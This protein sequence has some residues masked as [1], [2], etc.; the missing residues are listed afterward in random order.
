MAAP[1]YH[2]GDLVYLTIPIPLPDGTELEHPVLIISNE[3]PNSIENSYIAVMMSATAHT[4]R[5]SFP[6]GNEMFESPL[7]K[8]GCNFRM[9]IIMNVRESQISRFSNRIKPV[10]LK[11]L[12]KQINERIFSV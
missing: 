12:L 6:C 11:A 9:H 4:D 3:S 8:S 5:F 2:Q 7:T 1:K 10:Y